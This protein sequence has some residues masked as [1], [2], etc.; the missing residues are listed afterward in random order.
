M[1]YNKVFGIG[2]HKT[3]TSSLA[4]ALTILG[5]KNN[6]GLDTLNKVWG[7]KK[8]ITLL[9][10][11]DYQ[12]FFEFINEY[13]STLD[14]PWY[15]LYKEL[16]KEFPKS[17]FILTIR[18]ED[19]WLNSCRNF[20]RGKRNPLHNIIYGVNKFIGNE[21][22]YLT[23]YKEH[24]EEVNKYFRNRPEDLLIVNWE[25]GNGWKEICTFLDKPIVKLPFPHLNQGK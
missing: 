3:G 12:P 5:F 15:L 17:K 11:R 19:K 16:D 1:T 21:E 13:D 14:N 22:I 24:C 9:K 25:K 2:F 4:M 6:R 10:E 23:K 18:A 7:Q 8:S 20:F